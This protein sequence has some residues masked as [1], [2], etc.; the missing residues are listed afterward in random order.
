MKVNPY[1]NFDVKAHEAFKFYLS[2]FGRKLSIQKM[3]S[4]P[5]IEDLPKEEKNFA[6]N[7]SM[8]NG[9]FFIASDIVKSMGHVCIR[10]TAMTSVFLRTEMM[11]PQ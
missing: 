5:V 2:V 1:L 7:V 10:A 6:L 9:Q 4:A 11:K 8:G 3:S